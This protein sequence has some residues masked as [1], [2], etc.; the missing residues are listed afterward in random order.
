MKS[1]QCH[2]NNE[3]G[4]SKPQ[5]IDKKVIFVSAVEGTIK[6]KAVEVAVDPVEIGSG[7]AWDVT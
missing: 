7:C 1:K 4:C 3:N 5:S 6:S 2:Q